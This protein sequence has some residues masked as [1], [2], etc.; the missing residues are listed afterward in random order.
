MSDSFETDVPKDS[1]YFEYIKIDLKN[2]GTK[3]SIISS[4]SKVLKDFPLNT[5]ITLKAEQLKDKDYVPFG[6]P[7]SIELCDFM[8]KDKTI[9]PALLKHSNFTSECPIKAAVYVLNDYKMQSE[10]IPI[11]LDSGSYKLIAQ[12]HL[13]EEIVGYTWKGQLLEE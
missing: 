2:P 3:N 10:E 1:K 13:E 4:E 6:F 7:I 8:K 5:I 12:F 9:I 11:P